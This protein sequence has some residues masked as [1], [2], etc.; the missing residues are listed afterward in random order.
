MPNSLRLRQTPRPRETHLSFI[1]RLA[2]TNGVGVNEF[3]LDMGFSFKRIISQ[4]KQALCDLAECGGLTTDQVDDLMSWTGKTAG[5]V[6]INFRN[7]IFGSRSL[8]NAT[9]RGCPV[10]L[11]NDA[12]ND[13]KI[14]ARAMTMRGD[15]QF[16]EV[17]MCV[18][19]EHPL[20]PLWERSNLSERYDSAARLTEILPNIQS[21]RLSV[22]SAPLSHYDFWL[23]QRLDTGRD[24]TWLS[25]KSVYAGSIFCRLLG[26]E[27]LRLEGSPDD[28]GALKTRAAQAKGFAV[29]QQSESAIADALES[30]AAYADGQNDEPKK[31]FGR[32]YSDLNTL[33]LEKQAFAPFRRLLRDCI[34]S[35]WPFGAGETVLGFTQHERKLHSVHSASRE[36]GIGPFL[37]EQFLAHAGALKGN[38]T[39]PLARRTFDA[40]S[41][42]EL[43]NEIPT[44]VGP[45]EM[46]KAMGATLSQ[47][48]SLEA[49]GVL[50]PRIDISTIKSPWRIAD[51]LDLVK[52]L[53]ALAYSV[54]SSDGRWETLQMAK[55]RSDMGVGATIAAARKGQLQLGR[56]S[57][58]V[59]YAGFCVL[60]AQI[61]EMA[62]VKQKKLESNAAK[63]GYV[64]PAVFG[65]SVG[66]R[67]SGWFEA[68]F[69]GGHTPA[70][71]LPH[72]IRSHEQT[73]VSSSDA[74]EFHKR[75]LTAAT[76]EKEFGVHRRTLLAKLRVARVGTF[77]PEG[78]DFGQI[79]LRDDVETVL[80]ATIKQTSSRLAEN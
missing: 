71:R 72:P 3:S 25:D 20:V 15:W 76:M 77:R 58:V 13:T 17:S 12:A 42:A 22:P 48:K 52:E 4:E 9:I 37:L 38:D 5:N 53:D 32:L 30:L 61:D 75:F 65:R 44:L 57:D 43:L 33:Y 16:R 14:P 39:R 78:Q 60:K 41:Y 10:C 24:K 36:T 70:T 50:V 69:V 45:I 64:T 23:D 1:S 46:R 62:P 31:A 35:T 74:V 56:Y 55:K 68:L 66:I 67:E 2:A 28:D 63:E 34:V 54:S 40:E 49:D 79:Y 29:A 73:L 27:L 21:G 8:R 11:K 19:H 47:L 6:Q 26:A 59:G 80:G 51:G 18:E 7:E